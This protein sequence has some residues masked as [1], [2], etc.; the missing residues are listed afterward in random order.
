[1]SLQ[2]HWIFF[3]IL[4][5][6]SS[7]LGTGAEQSAVVWGWLDADVWNQEI[8]VIFLPSLTDFVGNQ[9]DDKSGFWPSSIETN[10]PSEPFL[11]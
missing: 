4:F 11:I 2:E 9:L 6:I 5:S 10:A 3:L 7:Q 8:T 1:M